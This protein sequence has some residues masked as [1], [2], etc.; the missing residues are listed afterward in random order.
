MYFSSIPRGKGSKLS[1]YDMPRVI[2][3]LIAS[4]NNVYFRVPRECSDGAVVTAMFLQLKYKYIFTSISTQNHES[5]S[6]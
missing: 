2:K 6:I 4:S 1:K 3:P 5:I